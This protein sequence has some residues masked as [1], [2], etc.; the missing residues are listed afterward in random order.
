MAKKPPTVLLINPWIYDFAAYDFWA[1]PLGLLYIASIL[2]ENGFIVHLVDCL[3]SGAAENAGH[4]K[5]GDGHFQ[6]EQVEKPDALASIPRKYSRY[7]MSPDSFAAELLKLPHPDVIMVGSMMT[8]W[9]PGV[10]HV[11]TLVKD[12]FP[13]VPVILGGLYATLCHEHAVRYSGADVCIRG[14]GEMPVLK[15]VSRITNWDISSIPDPNQP[16][17]L[18]YPAFDLLKAQDVLCLITA[19]GCPYNCTYCASSLLRDAFRP[20]DPSKTSDEISY[21]VDRYQVRNIVFY[22]D[23]LL[24]K[25][26]DRF[27]PLFRKLLNK[28]STLNFHTPNGLHARKITAEVADL[29]CQT[30]FKTIRIGLETADGVMQ[31]KTGAKVTNREFEQ[32]VMHLRKAGYDG[33][34]IGVYLLAGLPGQGIDEVRRSIRYVRD[35]GARPYLAEYSPIPGTALWD[36]ACRHSAF[37][38]DEPLFHNNSILPC[39]KGG[40]S[41][42]DLYQLKSEVKDDTEKE[43]VGFREHGGA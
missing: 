7:G 20:R 27:I 18:P 32:A 11:I 37:N 14:E 25:A 33:K 34:D 12:C 15:T 36:D 38:L 24:Y 28:H 10:F 13:G 17:S 22:D 19:R 35:C 5:Y 3:D 29:M 31:M 16:D 30:G 42:E 4:R 23:A 40:L 6:K 39:R 9:Y 26:E 8:Y 43:G 21:W 41:W 1:R 2:R